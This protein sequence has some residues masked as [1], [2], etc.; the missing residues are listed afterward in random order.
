MPDATELAAPPGREPASPLVP[1]VGVVAP[2]TPAAD[3]EVE[4]GGPSGGPDSLGA[5]LERGAGQSPTSD[6]R[7]S[8]SPPPA[9]DGGAA[10]RARRAGSAPF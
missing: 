9:L 10:R 4:A 7:S 2:P 8:V 3:V 5:Y 6:G 1:W